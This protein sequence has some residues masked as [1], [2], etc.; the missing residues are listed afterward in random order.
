[1]AGRIGYACTPISLNYKTSRSFIV[2]NFS[3][4]RFRECVRL[5]LG[6]LKKILEWNLSQ[7][8]Y[9]FRISSDIIPFG[10]HPVNQLNWELEF[11]EQLQELGAFIKTHHMRVSMHP[12]QY[13]VLN[14][15]NDDI[16]QRAVA[17]LSYH[18]R[19]LDGMGLSGEHKLILHAGGVYGDKHTAM[20]RFTENAAHLPDEIKCRLVIENDDKNYTAA[21]VLE[22]ADS[23]RLPV[24]YDNL[25]D[26]LNPSIIDRGVRMSSIEI[27]EQASKTWKPE[28]G[29]M[30]CHYSEQD[31]IKKGG[32][33]SRTVSTSKFLSYWEL[34]SRYGA[35]VM[36]EVKDKELSAFKCIR[37]TS[38]KVSQAVITD[39]WA[40]YK[41][42]VMEKSYG[43]YKSC[44]RLVR[45][46]TPIRE[47]FEQID[48]S[49]IKAFDSGSFVNAAQHVY[50]YV[51]EKVSVKER[52]E[53]FTLLENPQHNREKIKTVL[54][55]LCRKYG[56]D[57]INASYYFIY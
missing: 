20:K 37:S 17:D 12:G 33:H 30:K 21:D 23:V 13:T 9:M 26:E 45:S 6:D 1:M 24:V 15:P 7:S 32:A 56:T 31:E 35:D 57:Y 22:L 54:G 44:S 10:S 43:D 49:L 14:S 51:K 29:G 18:C 11:K 2:K 38:D 3:E 19:V 16:V 41:Y 50:G 53:F 4:D 27:M 46:G 55:R 47:L 48:E 36:L 5:N 42:A 39:T 34:A 8:I 52:S 40:K 28:D 25:H